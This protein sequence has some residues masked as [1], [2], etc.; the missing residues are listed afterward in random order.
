MIDAQEILD[1]LNASGNDQ[2]F[3][4]RMNVMLK[5]AQDACSEA[6]EDARDSGYAS[7]FEAGE[8]SMRNDDD[9]WER[10]IDDHMDGYECPNC[11]YR[12]NGLDDHTST[13]HVERDHLEQELLLFNRVLIHCTPHATAA[14]H[15]RHIHQLLDANYHG[16]TNGCLKPGIFCE[17]PMCS[18]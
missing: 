12:I 1:T 17:C 18:M 6:I 8:E 11:A 14:M 15:S 2:E 10:V 7:G 9:Y 4:E 16:H 3:M 5:E 13:L